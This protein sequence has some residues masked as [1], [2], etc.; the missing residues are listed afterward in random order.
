MM[1]QSRLSCI[2]KKHPSK[3]HLKSM[4]IEFKFDW[5]FWFWFFWFWFWF[6]N[7]INQETSF[8]GALQI[9]AY[10]IQIW[11]EILILIFLILILIWKFDKSRNILPRCISNL[12]ILN[13][14]SNQT[15]CDQNS[16]GLDFNLP[17]LRFSFQQ[18]LI[19]QLINQIY[20]TAGLFDG[21]FNFHNKLAN[22]RRC[23]SLE[24]LEKYSLE[25]YSL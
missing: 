7:L 10:W 12:C 17:I 15:K 21:D 20:R 11:F 2:I 13:T 1:I 3:V 5:K 8:Q 24:H 22:L 9:Y 6:E 14:K 4:H 16:Q 23:T 18:Y 19:C 25:K